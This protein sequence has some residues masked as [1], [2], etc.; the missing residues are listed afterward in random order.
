MSRP[1]K[2]HFLPQFYLRSFSEDQ[3]SLYQIQKTTGEFV[4]CRIKDLA[5]IRDFHE[6]DADDVE[7]PHTLEKELATVEGQ[8]STF[9]ADLLRDGLS[10]GQ[11]LVETIGFVSLL[12]MRVPAIKR[13]IEES[14]GETVRTAAEIMERQGKLPNPPP[15]F[16]EAL[17]VANLKITISN[18]KCLELMFGMASNPDVLNIMCNMQATLFRA[19]RGSFITGD[20]PVSL[21]HEDK[22]SPY[23]VGPATPGV[24]ITVPLTSSALLRLRHSDEEDVDLVASTEE[25]AE[26]NRRTIVMAE[27]YLYT[28]CSP[29][30]IG[31]RAL[32]LKDSFAGFTFDMLRTGRETYQVQRFIPVYPAST[33]QLVRTD[34]ALRGGLTQVLATDEQPSK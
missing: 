21:Y 20:Q 30:E 14:L 1:R 10:N 15:G 6:I 33:C 2:H 3:N 17:R 11:A 26:F 13:H 18:W 32:L 34:T 8:M 27:R 31:A 16:E 19:S 7:D 22:N 25:I 5:A 28:G 9:L 24:E 4:G 12:R 23:G 29:A